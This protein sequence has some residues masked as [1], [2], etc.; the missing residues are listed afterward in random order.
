VNN[1]RRLAAYRGELGPERFGSL[2]AQATGDADQAETILSLL[3]QLDPG[4]AD[5]G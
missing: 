4:D 1:L 5:S 3:G 2:L